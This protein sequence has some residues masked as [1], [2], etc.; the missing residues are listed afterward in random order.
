MEEVR[1]TTNLLRL[2]DRLRAEMTEAYYDDND[3]RMKMTKPSIK[4]SVKDTYGGWFGA[5]LDLNITL[6]QLRSITD[7]HD[8]H[9]VDA[10]EWMGNPRYDYKVWKAT[11]ADSIDITMSYEFD[12]LRV[13]ND[14]GNFIGYTNSDG[15][16]VLFN[17]SADE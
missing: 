9:I 3:D 14:E 6:K 2:V 5:R 17:H 8:A 11:W 12:D 4:V 10:R 7:Q 1:G 16:T 15:D 13:K